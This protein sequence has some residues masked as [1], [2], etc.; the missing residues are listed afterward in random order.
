M[1]NRA[2]K[3]RYSINQFIANT[4][5]LH[6]GELSTQDWKAI[7]TVSDWLLNFR[8]ATSQMSATS[9]PMLSST[10][11]I[12]RALQRTLKD[13]LKALPPNTPPELVL[14]LTDAHRKLSDY[15]YKY[16]QSPFYMWAAILDPRFNYKKL[17]KDY[18]S[19]AELS[20]YLETQKKALREYLDNNYPPTSSAAS[21]APAS[22]ADSDV[23]DKIASKPG[24]INFNFAAF[25]DDSDDDQDGD[26]LNAYFEC[27]AVAVERVFSGGRDTISLRR[28]RLNPETIRTLMLV[29]HQ[30]HLKRK[31]LEDALRATEAV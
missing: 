13:K 8:A 29:K 17:K 21:E 11:Y 30:L 28:A 22:A 20:A 14:G 18:A 12:F 24:A 15:Y 16:D 7:E 23:R 4:P 27:S 9:R 5:D 1:M 19:D 26:E 3:Y 6:D 31:V 25:D 10:H 2:L